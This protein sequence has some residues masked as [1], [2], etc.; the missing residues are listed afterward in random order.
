MK[1]NFKILNIIFIIIEVILLF[2][3]REIGG[4]L[5]KGITSSGFVVIGLI[6]VVYAINAK[7]DRKYPL[8]MFFGLFASMVGDVVLQFDFMIGAIIFALGHVFYFI[9]FC[10]LKPFKNCDTIPSAVIFIGA[11]LLL[12]LAPVFDF[13]SDIMLYVCLFYALIIS[14]MLGKAISNYLREKSAFYL[15]LVI[16]AALFFFSDLM[17]VFNIFG[18]APKIADTL[19][20]FS[21]WPAQTVLAFT[22]YLHINQSR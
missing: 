15:I 12:T 5:F 10:G 6:N 4:T 14:F 19:C 7:S 2:S 18:G 8:T 1:K 13:G 16:G 17:L 11:A 9:A 3:Y 22:G 20:L 21:Y